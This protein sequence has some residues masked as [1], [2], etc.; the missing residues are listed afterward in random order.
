MK[1]KRWFILSLSLVLFIAAC[2]SPPP[3]EIV[4]Q[5]PAGSVK[6]FSPPAGQHFTLGHEVVIQSTSVDGAGVQRVELLVNNQVVRTTENPQPVA[7]APFVVSQIW[8]PR[9]AGQY[10]VQVQ[11]YNINKAKH[12]SQP[13]MIAIDPA[14]IQSP[15]TPLATLMPAPPTP[16]PLPQSMARD[17]INTPT[18]IPPTPIGV[19][20]RSALL[21]QPVPGQVTPTPI[22]MGQPAMPTPA[23]NIG[24]PPVNQPVRPSGEELIIDNQ[25]PEFQTVGL[26]FVGDGGR[27]YQG[28]CAWA[29]RGSNNNAYWVPHLPAGGTYE[30]FAWWCGDPNH[31]QATEAFFFVRSAD[32]DQRIMVNF[33]EE[34][35]QWNSLGRYF[36]KAGQDGF[37]N[38]NG[39]FGGNVIADA[40]KFVYV[41]PER[42]PAVVPTPI[43]TPVRW[44][45]H[46]PAPY[47]QIAAGDFA[48]RLAV[49]GN[50][51][52]RFT[53]VV[54]LNEAVFDDCRDFP[55]DGCGGTVPGWVVQVK[56][57]ARSHELHVAYRVSQDYRHMALISPPPTLQEKQRI[58]LSA[59]NNSTFLQI[60]RYPAPDYS[61]H[62][63][64]EQE[65]RPFDQPLPPD[66]L[67]ELEYLIQR[68]NS[69]TLESPAW[70]GWLTLYGWGEWTAFTAEDATR[71]QSLGQRLL[72]VSP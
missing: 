40:V 45:N 46:P 23:R 52:Y 33:Q 7:N 47:E 15:A 5:Q 20:T 36:F 30:V 63:F 70:E 27:S 64:G 54:N 18:P 60:D 6:I 1:I 53:P 41:S 71:V 24:L 13:I 8:Q 57:V 34:A 21:P 58:F 22:E 62:I 66:V 9:T 10:L 38:I 68:Y 44:T 48:T 31:D 42:L 26:W 2:Q 50:Q 69:V 59:G 25:A 56:H 35:G 37:V 4:V 72:G 49:T 29:P 19:P 28:D 16:T 55:R 3:S 51:F 11:A 65:G 61:W 12:E 39:G 67:P 14:E 43:P 32:G 17:I